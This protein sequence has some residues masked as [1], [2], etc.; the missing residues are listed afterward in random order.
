MQ[1]GLRKDNK[2]SKSEKMKSLKRSQEI[3]NEEY[4]QVIDKLKL[5]SKDIDFMIKKTEVIDKKLEKMM[6]KYQLFN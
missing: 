6:E 4:N 1:N 2:T 3:L 5:Y